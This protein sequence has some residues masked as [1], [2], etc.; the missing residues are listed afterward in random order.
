M[1]VPARVDMII[2]F[3]MQMPS[4]AQKSGLRQSRNART[5]DIPAL[6]RKT[7]VPMHRK[8]GYPA[9]FLFVNLDLNHEGL[10][11]DLLDGDLR[12]RLTMALATTVVGLGLVLED[13]DFLLLALLKNLARDLRT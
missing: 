11:L 6:R 5:D 7:A 3:P 13:E 2:K 10:R 8:G 12:K 9:V 1:K 4:Q